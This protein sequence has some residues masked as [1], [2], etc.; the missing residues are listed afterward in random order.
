MSAGSV[1]PYRILEPLGAGAHGQV[2]LA[3]DTRLGRR[4]ALKTLRDSGVHDASEARHRVLRE[5]RA[6]ARLNHPHIAAVYDVV[7]TAEALHIVMEYVAGE[8]LAARLRQGPIRPLQVLELGSQLASALAHAH[9]QGVIHRD[10][11]PSNIALSPEGHAKILDF[12]VARTIA[13]PSGDATFSSSS[14]DERVLVGTPPYMPPEHI[15]GAPVDERGDLYSLAV[16]LYEALTGRRPFD[17]PDVASLARAIL[18]DPTPRA[19]SSVTDLPPALDAVVF[20]AMARDPA[21]RHAHARDL[22]SDLRHLLA[23][24]VDAPTVSRM[25]ARPLWRVTG[26][27]VVLSSVAALAALLATGSY[28]AATAGRRHSPGGAGSPPAGPHVVA[29]L[30]LLGAESDPQYEALAAGA[31]DSL[32]TAL[33]KLDGVTVVSRA[34]MLKH[35]DRQLT[36]DAIAREVGASLLVDGSVQRSGEALRLTV[37][38]LTPGSNV[39]QWQESYD[40]DFKDV[41]RLQRDVAYKVAQS[42]QVRISPNTR[43]RLQRRPT[44]SVEALAEYSQ[45]RAFME[46]PDVQGNLDRAIPLFQAALHRDPRFAWAH[47]GLGEAYW[48]RFRE[49]KQANWSLL[50][51]DS[52]TEALRLDPQDTSV[53]YSL[54]TIYRGT[55]RLTEAIDELRDIVA[56]RPSADDA[57][58]LLGEVLIESGDQAAGM[59]ELQEAVNLRPG[60]A[61]HHQSLGLAH[62]RAGRHVEAAAA[63]KRITELQPDSAWGFQLLGTAYHAMDDISAAVPNYEKAIAL[64]NAKAYSN[65]GML[66]YA[67]GNLPEA[68][69][70]LREA[71][72]RD[73][74]SLKKYSLGDVYTR[75]GRTREALDEYRG[76]AALCEDELRI[77]PRDAEA[78]ARLSLTYLKLGRRREAD[79]RMREAVA[80]APDNADVRFAQAIHA[81][82]VGSKDEAIDALRRA[83]EHGYSRVRVAQEPLLAPLHGNVE[84]KRLV[85]PPPLS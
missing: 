8:T 40:G 7:E 30:P 81:T 64:G 19:R 78:V 3:E 77:N 22:E 2:C 72:K 52:V 60:F 43:A 57:H 14:T 58:R 5:A 46:R 16:T 11:K 53:R 61:S 73:A 42:L 17:A 85:Q 63:F 41:M 35:R 29:V 32:I 68:E 48:R 6:A 47:A 83:I 13:I 59:A 66:Y 4:V 12:G 26:R 80:L 1:G 23:T 36:P 51:R 37:S 18:T 20:R 62:Y 82:L 75:M 69:R 45:A 55:G 27:P 24:L 21:Q 74:N 65:L 70:C 28:F 9:G 33:S 50:A 34:A 79:T 44:E 67:R 71:L 76:A 38:L 31:S 10:L 39:V 54:A 49:T 84:Y 25:G 15:M 56:S